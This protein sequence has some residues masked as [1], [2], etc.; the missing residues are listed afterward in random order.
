MLKDIY[1]PLMVI[2]GIVL[3]VIGVAYMD[4]EWILWPFLVW[5]TF[6]ALGAIKLM[7][8]RTK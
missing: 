6:L 1:L 7:N 4:Q 3:L 2:S 8:T 5:L